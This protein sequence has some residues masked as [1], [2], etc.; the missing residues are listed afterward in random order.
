MEASGDRRRHRRA[1]QAGATTTCHVGAI[2]GGPGEQLQRGWARQ[3]PRLWGRSGAGLVEGELC[4]EVAYGDG[5][6]GLDGGHGAGLGLHGD[7]GQGYDS[8]SG[9][10]LGELSTA[11]T[12]PPKK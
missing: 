12:E 1:C 8:G 11:V 6:R 9:D 4:G 2:D 10:V 7:L 3:P 5:F